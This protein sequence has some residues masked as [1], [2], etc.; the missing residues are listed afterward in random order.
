MS[1]KYHRGLRNSLNDTKYKLQFASMTLKTNESKNNING[2]KSDISRINDFSDE[3]G[4]NT[5]N[6]SSNLG[7]INDD[8]G[9]ISSNASNVAGI[10]YK[11]DDNNKSYLEKINS[12]K[13]YISNN[14]K[15]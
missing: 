3:I 10:L 13:N 8:I 2:I 1:D 14:F 12:N 4:N 6:I 11:I 9:N 7:K 5:L 15:K